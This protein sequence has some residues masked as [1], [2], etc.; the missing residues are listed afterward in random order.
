MYIQGFYR[1]SSGQN[2][3]HLKL[4]G[5][6]LVVVSR[7]KGVETKSLNPKPTLLR[8]RGSGFSRDLFLMD[9]CRDP[10]PHFYQAPARTLAVA[11]AISKS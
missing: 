4:T 9:K 5:I 1:D 3:A 11:C 2:P 6:T 7:E 8:V 10:S